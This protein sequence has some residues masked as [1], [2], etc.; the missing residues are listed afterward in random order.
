ML[1]WERA[2]LG[3]AEQ[4]LG[5]LAAHWA[6]E[7]ESRGRIAWQAMQRGYLANGRKVDRLRFVSHLRAALL[8]VLAIHGWRDA[9]RARAMDI[10][11]WDRFLE[12]C[13]SW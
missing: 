13:E 3:E 8:R 7:D 5:N 6:F 11:R 9:G 1:D 10:H 12:E 2:G 4:D